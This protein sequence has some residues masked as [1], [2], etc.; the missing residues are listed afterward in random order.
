M[1]IKVDKDVC[2]G[3]RACVYVR[4]YKCV[5]NVGGT[6]KVKRRK[7]A[8]REEECGEKGEAELG[9]GL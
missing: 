4:A 2:V 8:V 1:G 3:M 5:Y 6:V 9:K 7:G